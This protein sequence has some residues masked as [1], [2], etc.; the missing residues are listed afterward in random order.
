MAIG[1]SWCGRDFWRKWF[2][3]GYIPL[4]KAGLSYILHFFAQTLSAEIGFNPPSILQ[5]IAESFFF[6]SS[7]LFLLFEY[8]LL[9]FHFEKGGGERDRGHTSQSWSIV[10]YYL[11]AL[12]L[13]KS[14]VSRHPKVTWIESMRINQTAVTSYRPWPIVFFW[15]VGVWKVFQRE[16]AAAKWCQKARS[17]WPIS[18]HWRTSCSI[19]PLILEIGRWFRSRSEN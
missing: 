7:F 5:G 13:L 6:P 14:C 9:F 17:N 18:I 19:I 15:P 16:K 3:N 1:K 8:F 10:A 4:T 11:A 2:V 12:W